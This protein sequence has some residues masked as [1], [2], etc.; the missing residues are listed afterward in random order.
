MRYALVSQN[1]IRNFVEWNGDAEAWSPPDGQ[2]VH[3]YPEGRGAIGWLWNDGAPVDPNPAPEPEP[4]VPASL[5]RKQIMV[6]LDTDGKLNAAYAAAQQAGGLIYQRWFSDDWA[7]ADLQSQP[8]ASMIAALDI[9][10]PTFW[11][12]A[13][14]QPT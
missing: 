12:A 1:I 10:L 3:E 13:A 5:K 11:A 8:F 14:A 4:V 7:L 9:D 6:Q 2:V